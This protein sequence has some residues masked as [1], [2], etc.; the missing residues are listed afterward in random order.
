MKTLFCGLAIAALSLTACNDNGTTKQTADTNAATPS[1]T[2]NTPVFPATPIKGMVDG[3]LNL[4]NAL[5]ADKSEE[6]ASAGTEI[7]AAM[8]TLD[9]AS[10]SATQKTTYDKVADDVRE[11]AEHIGENAGKIDHQREH[12]EM[13]STDMYDLVKVFGGGQQ[14]YQDFCPMYN[15]SKGGAWLSETKEIKNPYFGA[16]M[17]KCGTVKEELQP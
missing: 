4:K 2:S 7:T 11:H 8:K 6:A 16:K 9:V 1:E 5:A 3:Y 15:D 14:L 13:L 12:F 17:L 10:M